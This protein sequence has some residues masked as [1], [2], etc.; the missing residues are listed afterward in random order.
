MAK[1]KIPTKAQAKAFLA[2]GKAEVKR[3]RAVAVKVG[4]PAPAKEGSKLEQIIGMMRK[5]ATLA[6]MSQA[7][8]WKPTSV[9]GVIQNAV[10][11]RLKMTVTREKVEGRGSVFTVAP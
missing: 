6:E 1:R 2:K 4:E 10:K 9:R 8:S 7:T 11:G 3:Q 5:G